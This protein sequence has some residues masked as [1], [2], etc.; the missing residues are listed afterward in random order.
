MAGS[1]AP[2]IVTDGLVLALDA[3]NKKSYPGTGTTW[4]DL[5]GN[6]NNGTLYNSPT[7]DSNNGGNLAYDGLNTYA[8]GTEI[9]PNRFTLST[10]FK[11][12]GV[13]SN[14]DSV[15]ATL[16]CNNPQYYLNKFQFGISH[17]WLDQTVIFIV[18]NVQATT[19]GLTALQNTLYNAVGTY[20][21]FT[22]KVYI[23]GVLLKTVASTTDPVYP[24]S[25]DTSFRIGMWGYSSFTRNFN[26]NIYQTYLYD[27][28]L[29]ADEILQNY[30][31]TKLRFG[32]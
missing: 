9:Q 21:G 11:A 14:N 31:A 18:Q 5:S 32:L 13:P 23:N 19:A 8:K 30:N 24:N 3:A 6:G 29:A 28:A 25:G 1:V 17:S 4:T 26:G 16:F 2:N 7:F 27:R 12:T 10:W 15:G 22:L 20:D